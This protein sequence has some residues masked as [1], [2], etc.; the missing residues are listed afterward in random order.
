[1]TAESVLDRIAGSVRAR[2]E[3]RKKS[4]PLAELK[5]RSAVARVPRS[6][7]AALERAGVRVIAEIKFTSPSQG[8][9]SNS[10]SLSPVA[11]ARAYLDNGAAAIS[12]LTEQD[13]FN[14]KL[15][16]LAQVRAA[17]PD[18][19]L[20]MKDFVVDEYQLHE[21]RAI[22]ADAALLIVALL[23]EARSRELLAACRALGLSAL[24][25]VHNEDEFA[26]A[27]RIGADLIGVNNRDLK[28]LSISLDTSY[29]LARLDR[30][31][32]CL[33]SESGLSEGEELKKLAAA[34]YSGFL[35]GTSFMKTADPGR[36]L[37]ELMG[38]AR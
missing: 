15:E 25:E 16:Y 32:A 10:S 14:G 12:V 17:F 13:H 7:K 23:G 28:T 9:L 36:A 3:E 2:L 6:L 38:A 34:G 19:V 8:E 1:M 24:V 27:T 11:A 5:K 37:A 33:I 26:I 30:R 22:G 31:G 20:L 4:Q 21:A 29:R 18:A 35:I